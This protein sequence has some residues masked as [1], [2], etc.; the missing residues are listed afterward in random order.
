[1]RLINK[2][3]LKEI[4]KDV[5]SVDIFKDPLQL[6]YYSALREYVIN[7]KT[8]SGPKNKRVLIKIINTNEHALYLLLTVLSIAKDLYLDQETHR[9]STGTVTTSVYQKWGYCGESEFVRL[10]D[11][12]L[13]IHIHYSL[14]ELFPAVVFDKYEQK[15][16]W[17]IIKLLNKRLVRYT[18]EIKEKYT[19]D[20]QQ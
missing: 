4:E 7:L 11:F 19:K 8:S 16:T 2:D 3:I 10:T 5:F 12:G 17:D 6:A 9:L 20:K 1:M 15:S 14:R 18:P 13:Y